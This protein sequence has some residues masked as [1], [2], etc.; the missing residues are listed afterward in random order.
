LKLTAI[1]PS[2]APRTAGTFFWSRPS[3]ARLASLRPCASLKV[4]SGWFFFPVGSVWR[5]FLSLRGAYS[6]DATAAVAVPLCSGIAR[7]QASTFRS[8]FHLHAVPLFGF[9]RI[10]SRIQ[11]RTLN[12]LSI[13]MVAYENFRTKVTAGVILTPRIFFSMPPG[14]VSFP[15]I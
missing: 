4:E 15:R 1:E 9:R 10:S 7:H 13:A 2:D 6:L 12:I 14:S 11:R 3:G 5:P 8:R